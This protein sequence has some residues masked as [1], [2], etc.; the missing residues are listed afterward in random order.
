MQAMQMYS[1]GASPPEIRAEIEKKYAGSYKNH[2]PTPH[3]PAP[4]K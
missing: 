3:P 4:A 1:S 2:T